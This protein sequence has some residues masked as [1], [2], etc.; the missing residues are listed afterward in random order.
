MPVPT[1]VQTTFDFRILGELEVR[2]DGQAAQALTAGQRALLGILL[3][4]AN[5]VVPRE[6]LARALWPDD[7]LGTAVRRLNAQVTGLRRKLGQG[8]D[9]RLIESRPEGYVLS[10]EEDE[11]DALRFLALSQEGREALARGDA[12]TAAEALR[13][14]LAL[15]RGPVLGGEPTGPAEPAARRL[16]SLRATATATQLEAEQAVT[17][18]SDLAT[19]V[20]ALAR[21]AVS[22]P[23]P[24]EAE[25]LAPGRD[26]DGGLARSGPAGGSR[27]ARAA[28]PLRPPARS[29]PA[30]HRGPGCGRVPAPRGE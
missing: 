16:E 1:S 15:W 18:E 17:R 4:H 5:E 3:L 21:I 19:E 9:R 8:G 11:L 26:C 24:P 22:A 2:V 6:T 7:T 25:L 28:R 14:A 20:A 13:E 29:R 12:E 27:Q 23:P 30:D 10:V